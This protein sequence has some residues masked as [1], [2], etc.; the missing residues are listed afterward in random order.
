MVCKKLQYQRRTRSRRAMSDT[1][2]R[3]PTGSLSCW[4]ST[5]CTFIR[6]IQSQ[7]G[8]RYDLYYAYCPV[9]TLPF[10]YQ[11]TW[12]IASKLGQRT[13]DR[14][15][16]D[17][18]NAITTAKSSA[19]YSGCSGHRCA[20]YLRQS[21]SKSTAPAVTLY[22]DTTFLRYHVAK[23]RALEPLVGPFRNPRP[24]QAVCLSVCLSVRPC[25]ACLPRWAGTRTS[26]LSIQ[27]SSCFQGTLALALRATP[28]SGCYAECTYS[29]H[30]SESLCDDC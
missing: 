14:G 24:S 23:Q 19:L 8:L 15:Q 13:E 5:L 20:Q 2:G 1:A 12:S 28:R 30:H 25:Q 4:P 22:L 27:S 11:N 29:E 17:N 16:C 3:K 10:G 9:T 18:P 26:L 6:L 21:T 7:C